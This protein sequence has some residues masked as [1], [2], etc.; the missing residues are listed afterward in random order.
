MPASCR[1][2]P[3]RLR[4]GAAFMRKVKKTV[5]LSACYKK[6]EKGWI[7][8]QKNIKDEL[9]GNAGVTTEGAIGGK[10]LSIKKITHCG[11][12]KEAIVLEKK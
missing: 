1:E 12:K 9:M 5:S 4:D 8:I 7:S 10:S 6:Q 3:D 2:G 11:K